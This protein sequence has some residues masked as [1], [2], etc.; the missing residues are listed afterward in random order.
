VVD[1]RNVAIDGIAD[2]ERVRRVAA[3]VL[4]D[5]PRNQA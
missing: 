5:D 2:P 4:G 1:G 3:A